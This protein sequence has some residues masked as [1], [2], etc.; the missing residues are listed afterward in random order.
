MFH[1]SRGA[2][3]SKSAPLIGSRSIRPAGGSGGTAAPLRGE[4]ICGGT[5]EIRF[6]HLFPL[7]KK[8][9]SYTIN[10]MRKICDNLRKSAAKNKEVK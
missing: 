2:V 5:A 8:E 9:N 7:K 6:N 1:G 3:F 10:L 4:P